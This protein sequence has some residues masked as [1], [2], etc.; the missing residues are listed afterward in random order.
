MRPISW[1]NSVETLRKKKQNTTIQPLYN[2][3]WTLGVLHVCVVLPSR[4]ASLKKVWV[5][6]VKLHEVNRVFFLAWRQ[7]DVY[8]F[9]AFLHRGRV[10][11]LLPFCH[12]AQ[13]EQKLPLFCSFFFC[14][15]FFCCDKNV[16]KVLADRGWKQNRHR[17]R[18]DA[19]SWGGYHSELHMKKRKEKE[20]KILNLITMFTI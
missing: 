10:A 11:R 7:T 17:C 19:P 15:F 3:K 14:L 20:Q 13:Q 8:T 18:W 12:S 16:K 2:Q 6:I 4:P 9:G 1:T 5:A